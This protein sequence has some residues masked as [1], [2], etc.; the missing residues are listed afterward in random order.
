MGNFKLFRRGQILLYRSDHVARELR[1]P[2]FREVQ[3]A[4]YTVG[5]AQLSQG[6]L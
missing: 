3:S 4:G 5:T 2:P 1:I 6:D